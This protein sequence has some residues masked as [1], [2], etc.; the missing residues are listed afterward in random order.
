M[1]LQKDA[2]PFGAIVPMPC[3]TTPPVYSSNVTTI[4]FQTP[5][6]RELLVLGFATGGPSGDQGNNN[7]VTSLSYRQKERIRGDRSTG[8]PFAG[9]PLRQIAGT[10]DNDYVRWP[11]YW[12]ALDMIL[13]GS[14]KMEEKIGG[15]DWP[16]LYELAKSS[17]NRLYGEKPNIAG[18]IT[19]GQRLS[20]SLRSL[21]SADFITSLTLIGLC[22]GRVS[23][24]KSAR[25]TFMGHN[26]PFFFAYTPQVLTTAVELINFSR[27]LDVDMA[28]A[29]NGE[30]GH[31]QTMIDYYNTSGVLQTDVHDRVF[32]QTREI[33]KSSK[34]AYNGA[35]ATSAFAN[36]DGAQSAMMFR[37][38]VPQDT[39]GWQ[40]SKVATAAT[41]NM[42]TTDYILTMRRANPFQN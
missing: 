13:R 10:G 4:E 8:S 35:I 29:G 6:D 5:T 32:L 2:Y 20:I 41:L 36:I 42:Y 24:G 34:W 16:M 19:D 39:V 40:G 15:G 26:E 3:I 12:P 17:L 33:A 9:V 27:A 23:N 11:G 22:L 25:Q 37:E 7:L 18:F 1:F 14:A 28:D 21:D 30:L 38:V 31:V